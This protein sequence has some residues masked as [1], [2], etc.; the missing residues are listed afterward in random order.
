[1]ATTRNERW[2]K[3]LAALT[4]YINRTGTS[5]VPSNHVEILDGENI[6]LGAWVT[7]NR[8]RQRNGTL[9]Q[10]R[11][12]A[13]TSLPGWQWGKQKP[14]RRYVKQRD[15]LIF[16]RYASGSTAKSLA[17]EYGLSRQRIHQIVRRGNGNVKEVEFR[18]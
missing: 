15:I 6:A 17:D 16:E 12:D 2:R 14:G 5:M 7:Y 11:I 18:S 3:Q 9:G 8:Q 13:L 4:Q 1:M 10:D